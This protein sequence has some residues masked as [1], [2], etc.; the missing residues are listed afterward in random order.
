MRHGGYRVEGAGRLGEEGLVVV[1]VDQRLGHLVR[2]R[3]RVRVRVR[4]R[5][6][7]RVRDRERV[8]ARGRGRGRGRGEG[9]LE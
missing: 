8:R 7:V 5:V 1:T 9:Y 6:W 2:G 3:G 4:A